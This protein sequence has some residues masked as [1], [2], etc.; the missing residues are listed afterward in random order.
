M[1]DIYKWTIYVNFNVKGVDRKMAE[2]KYEEF[3]RRMLRSGI[4]GCKLVN[5]S[6]KH[7]TFYHVCNK[8][9]E[10]LEYFYALNPVAGDDIL[11]NTDTSIRRVK[12]SSSGKT[13]LRKIFDRSSEGTA[14]ETAAV[15]K[16]VN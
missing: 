16:E 1:G 2:T 9:V 5:F 10:V 4:K 8:P 13:N 11:D 3:K 6:D 14:K 7:L 15:M 12:V